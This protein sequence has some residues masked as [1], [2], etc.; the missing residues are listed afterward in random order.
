[1]KKKVRN[2]IIAGVT[3]AVIAAVAI[4]GYHLYRESQKSDFEKGTE[5]AV[6]WTERNVNKAA[7]ETKKFF[8][9]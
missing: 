7:K 2:L 5:K 3:A 8:G 4:I 9:N 1:M 6:N